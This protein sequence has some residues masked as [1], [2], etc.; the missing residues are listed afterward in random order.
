MAE[1]RI[2]LRPHGLHWLGSPPFAEDLC[3]H[4]G[5]EF[6]IGDDSLLQPTSG[7]FTVSAAA[8]R[9]LRSLES[10]RESDSQH[11]G[12]S[13]RAVDSSCMRWPHPRTS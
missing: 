5:V 13:S 3:S 9:L 10:G 8:M 1:S 6:S 7:D 4:G 11:G 2:T 12:T